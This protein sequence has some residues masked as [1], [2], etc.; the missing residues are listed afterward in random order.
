MAAALCLL[1]TLAAAVG[2]VGWVL[3]D[4][5]AQ[6]REAEDK[7]RQ[8][9]DAA[10]R[11]LLSGNPQ[12]PELVAAVQQVQAQL[13]RGVLGEELRHQ[14]EQL[15][16][17][18]QML[19]SLE[20]ASLQQAMLNGESSDFA[21]RDELYAKGFAAYGLYVAALGPQETA[22]RIRQSAIRIHLLAALD[23]WATIRRLS[24]KESAA[25]L[26]AAADKADDYPWTRKL[27]R[28]LVR[29]NRAALEALAKETTGTAS[30]VIVSLLAQG[31]RRVGSFLEAERMLWRVQA[32][33]PDDFWINYEL[34]VT[35]LHRKSPDWAQIIR[36]Y[37][38]ALALRPHNGIV[39][40][41]LGIALGHDGRLVEAE[42]VFRKGIS[43]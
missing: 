24:N 13:G 20:Q 36:F 29:E 28:A 11:G 10:K 19:A 26:G 7:V 18:Q 14:A 6:R 40:N 21:H 34:A 17:D 22:D 35:I 9:L 16:R 37:Q 38:A 4:R 39:Y 25:L 12:D 30:P 2:S 27:R 8:A 1:V 32:D 43:I 3:G 31:L 23:Y 15:R 42:A 5:A 41:N 33:R